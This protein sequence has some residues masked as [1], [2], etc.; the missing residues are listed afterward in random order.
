MLLPED[1]R[2]SFD[3]VV[4]AY[5]EVRPTYPAGVFEALFELLPPEPDVVEVGPGTG[6]A[7]QDLL[8]RGAVVHAVEIGP[9]MAAKLR[10]NL[11]SDRLRVSVGDF[12]EMDIEAGSADAVFSATAYH[13]ISPM[14]QRDRP[15][16]ILRP[17]GILAI[18][19]LIQVESPDDRGFFAAAQPLYEQH[20][21]GH[22]GPPAPRRDKVEPEIR[23]A[24]R[25]DSR[26]D[27]LRVRS[28]DWN[29]TYRASD[30]R[31]L[32]LSYSSTQMMNED[33]RND[34]LSAMEAFVNERFA[35]YVTRPLV[36]TLTTARR[37]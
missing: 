24:L 12:E 16:A 28:Y 8:V 25:A 36:V 14:A 26:F 32:M 34:L 19:D 33:D 13:W 6:Q 15:A 20:G 9:A 11:Q 27:D 21:Q 30:Y 22:S 7:T 1:P 29:Q 5:D 18:V 35:G 23:A 2:L 37:I 17:D 10:S 31:K 3:S 4:E